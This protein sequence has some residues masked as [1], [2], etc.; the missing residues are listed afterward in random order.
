MQVAQ[1]LLSAFALGWQQHPEIAYRWR[2]ASVRAMRLTGCT[3]LVMAIQD[4]GWLDAMLRSIEDEFAAATRSEP[5]E[6]DLSV[7][8]FRYMSELWVSAAYG[9]CRVLKNAGQVDDICKVER[10][11]K[12]V[13]VPLFKYEIAEDR[14]LD[15]PLTLMATPPNHDSSDV[16]LYDPKDPH[17]SI[18]QARAMAQDGSMSWNVVDVKER[19]SLWVC[20][21]ELSD[22][23]LA[24][25]E[26]ETSEA[27]R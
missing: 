10:R 15:A 7:N 19:E 16:S 23:L 6:I 22:E 11:L 13:R 18:I 8:F 4:M 5:E 1:A 21:R 2:D 26:A 25:L 27:M 9:A 17:R 14:R 3:S 24:V 20:R 12:L